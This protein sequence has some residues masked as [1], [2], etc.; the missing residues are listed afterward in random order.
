LTCTFGWN[1][2]VKILRP[3]TFAAPH[4]EIWLGRASFS[5]R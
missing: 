1:S 2:P 3:I 4:V 5:T